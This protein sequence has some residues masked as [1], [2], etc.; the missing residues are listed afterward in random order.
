MPGIENRAKPL[1]LLPPEVQRVTV[2]LGLGDD[3][4]AGVET[5]IGHYSSCVDALVAQGAQSVTVMGIPISA[6]LGRRRVLELLAETTERTGLPADTDLEAVLAALRHLGATK[7]A[8]GSR[9]ADQ[10]NQALTHYLADGGV[11]VL[12]VTSVG[13]WMRQASAMSVE[14]GIK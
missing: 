9:W 7:L 3:T 10:L 4:Q 13:H 12:S 2:G 5:A 8:V 6:Q 11:E 1:E 14:E